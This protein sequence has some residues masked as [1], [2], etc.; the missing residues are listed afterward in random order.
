MQQPVHKATPSPPGQAR[1]PTQHS[2][3]VSPIPSP[4]AKDTV[5]RD[6]LSFLHQPIHQMH[7]QSH[8]ATGS[9]GSTTPP[10][11]GSAQPDAQAR[12]F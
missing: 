5:P 6:A 1:V 7:K 10:K 2:S 8:D 9:A 4:S 12:P 3:N 11:S